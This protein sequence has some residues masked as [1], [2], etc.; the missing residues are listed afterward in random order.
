VAAVLPGS[1]AKLSR[2]YVVYTAHADHLG[3]GRPINGDSIYNGAADD[4]SGVA[5]LLVIAKAFRSLPH[6]P[7]RSINFLVG[8]DIAQASRRPAWNPGDFFGETFGRK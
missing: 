7:A 2:E 4:A 8:Y 5:A 6:P 1:D 3:I